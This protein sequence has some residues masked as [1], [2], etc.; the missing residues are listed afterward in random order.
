M[1]RLPSDVQKHRRGSMLIDVKDGKPFV[2]GSV[3]EPAIHVLRQLPPTSL[4]C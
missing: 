2:N 1:V 3:V 4:P